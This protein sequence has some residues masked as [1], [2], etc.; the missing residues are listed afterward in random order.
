DRVVLVD[1]DAVVPHRRLQVAL[2][3]RLDLHVIRLPHQRRRFL[4]DF[5]RRPRTLLSRPRGP[6]GGTKVP[7]SRGADSK[8]SRRLLSFGVE[9]LGPNQAGRTRIGPI[10]PN[11]PGRS[12]RLMNWPGW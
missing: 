3:V 6:R 10:W 4:L 12:R 1:D 8:A 2:V 7:W 11:A 5:A 9:R